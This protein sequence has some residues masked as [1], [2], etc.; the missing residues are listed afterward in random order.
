M[1][2]FLSM[3]IA[4]LAAYLFN[5]WLSASMDISIKAMLDLIVFILVYIFSN[6]YLK[7]LRD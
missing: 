4:S 3:I 7:N 6:R 1:I 5:G 2:I